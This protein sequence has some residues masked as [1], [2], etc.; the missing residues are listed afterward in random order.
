LRVDI[1]HLRDWVGKTETATDT[2]HSRQ[3][4]SLAATL[5]RDELDPQPG[6]LVPP[7][8]HWIYFT[9]RPKASEIGP[10]GHAKRGGFLP[11][12][13]LPRRMWAGGRMRWPGAL[14]VGDAVTRTS[15]IAEVNHKPGKSGEL[16]FVLVKH[17]IAGPDGVC[18]EEEH[19]IVFRSAPDPDA[20]SPLAKA[21]PTDAIWSRIIEPNPVLLFRYS[22]LTFNGHRIH[23]D[24]AY[25]TEEEGYPGLIVHG[26][27]IATLLMDLCWREQP[28]RRLVRFDYRAMSPLFHIAPFTVNG[29]LD[30]HGKTAQLWAANADGGLAMQAEAEFAD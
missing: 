23:Y 16:V 21:A 7:A 18:V 12:V 3:L 15:T 5:D 4:A 11:P 20:P 17:T 29:R 10:D 22:A 26:P 9:P 24:L 1:D 13:D 19:D 14:R 28:E 27:L 25:V 2:L 30:D 8:G 6:D